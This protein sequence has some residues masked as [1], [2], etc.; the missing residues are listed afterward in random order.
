MRP[1]LGEL[2]RRPSGF[3]HPALACPP[4]ALCL[5]LNTALMPRL[6]P[7]CNVPTDPN[8]ATHKVPPKSSWDTLQTSFPLVHV[9]THPHTPPTA[10]PRH[11]LSWGSPG[12]TP[13]GPLQCPV[14]LQR[15]VKHVLGRSTPQVIGALRTL[16]S[17]SLGDAS[18]SCVASPHPPQRFLGHHASPRA[19]CSPRWPAPA[20]SKPSP[21]LG[22]KSQVH[23][24]PPGHLEEPLQSWLR[25]MFPEALQ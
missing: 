15:S 11:Q 19:L 16:I 7:V 8:Q 14:V 22:L 1:R 17:L 21:T 6:L 13:P 23:Q 18:S 2:C 5:T 12:H 9:W 4:T 25:M 3:T 24:L 10:R 20:H